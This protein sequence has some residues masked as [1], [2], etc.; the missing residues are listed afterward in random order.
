L[1]AEKPDTFLAEKRIKFYEN[2]KF[3]INKYEYY[4]PA[5]NENTESV[6]LYIMSY[7]SEINQVDFEDIRKKLYNSV[8]EYKTQ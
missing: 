2:L 1:E 4:Q 6:E 7:P 5:Y 8:Y 3:N